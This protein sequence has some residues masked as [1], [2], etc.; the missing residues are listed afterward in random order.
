MAKSFVVKYSLASSQLFTNGARFN[1]SRKVKPGPY[2]LDIDAIVRAIG[3]GPPNR[4]R[5]HSKGQSPPSLGG[6]WVPFF[7]RVFAGTVGHEDCKNTE[8]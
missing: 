7:R 3:A 2:L 4:W 5:W 1:P 8:N 6:A